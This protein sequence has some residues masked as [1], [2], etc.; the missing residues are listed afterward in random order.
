MTHIDL[1]H[2]REVADRLMDYAQVSND[3]INT[4]AASLIRS[5]CEIVEKLPVTADGVPI[6]PGMRVF[7]EML[8]DHE[9]DLDEGGI[10][11]A[12]K[13]DDG[14]IEIRDTR[15]EKGPNYCESYGSIVYSTRDSALA[16]AG[17]EKAPTPPTMPR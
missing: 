13:E 2:A 8:A 6:T 5:L 4:E 7:P 15:G 10:V 1:N 12:I 16:A 17:K 14:E 9:D 11:S 3:T